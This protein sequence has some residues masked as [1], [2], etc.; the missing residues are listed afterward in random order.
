MAICSLKSHMLDWARAAHCGPYHV[1]RAA[2]PADVL[3]RVVDRDREVISAAVVPLFG[4]GRTASDIV[5]P[6]CAELGV[7]VIEDAKFRPT[8]VSPYLWLS[9][10]LWWSELRWDGLPRNQSRKLVTCH[11]GK[12]IQV[13]HLLLKIFIG[14]VKPEALSCAPVN[15]Q[16]S[17]Y[18]IAVPANL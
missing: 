3:A 9:F 5:V 13:T 10:R 11:F 15:A 6:H 1:S 2:G 17:P 12:R 8:H 4:A 18:R 14:T 16:G 7:D